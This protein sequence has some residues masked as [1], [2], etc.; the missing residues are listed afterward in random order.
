MGEVTLLDSAAVIGFLNPHDALFVSAKDAVQSAGGRGRLIASVVTLAEVLTGAK[1][2]HHPVGPAR[3]LFADMIS[4]LVPVTA[5]VAETASSLRAAHRW[6]R[7]PDALILASAVIGGASH[8]ITG[9]RRWLE[10]RG[11][12]LKTHVLAPA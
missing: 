12:D 8:V 5:A 9:D 10:I 6:M 11:L 3:G 4:E 7:L 1:V 2:G